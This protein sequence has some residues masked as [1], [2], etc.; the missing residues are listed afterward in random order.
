MTSLFHSYSDNPANFIARGLLLASLIVLPLWY[1][2]RKVVQEQSK[3]HNMSLG[4]S[5]FPGSANGDI[6]EATPSDDAGR[7]SLLDEVKRRGRV[8]VQASNFKEAEALYHKGIEVSESMSVNDGIMNERAILYSNRSLARFQMGNL[9]GSGSDAREATTCDPTYLK[10]FWRLGQAC[11]ARQQYSEAME[12]YGAAKQLDANNKAVAKEWEKSRKKVD[13]EQKLLDE[14]C[15]M[16]LDDAP[17]SSTTTKTAA[18]VVPKPAAKK[19]KPATAPTKPSSKPTQSKSSS[20]KADDDDDDEV[21][22]TKSDT[23]R[24]YKIVGGKKTSYFHNEL[25]EEAKKLIGDIAPKKLENAPAEAANKMEG[26]SAWNKAGTWEEKNVTQWATNSL[27]EILKSTTFT[28][29]NMN[30]GTGGADGKQII[31]TK[32]P[33]CE[34]HASVATVRGKKR[35]IYEFSIVVDWSLTLESGECKGSLTFP[36]VDGTCEG[37]YDVTGYTVKGET[38]SEA[39]HILELFVKNGGMRDALTA[40][41]NKWVEHF[42]STY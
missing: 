39:R 13:E 1:I 40:S 15:N 30:I 10:G 8:T 28:I 24:G 32:V 37:V 16:S 25:T 20:T 27:T 26:A 38:P 23:A 41:L 12:A 4:L 11:F 42:Q 29:P 3:I 6:L 35:Y 7:R 31:I 34:G 33:T 36:D 19:P 17:K 22:F 9:T 2:R 18:A 5:A 21:E 14:A